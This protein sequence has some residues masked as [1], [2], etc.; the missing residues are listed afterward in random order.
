[1]ADDADPHTLP[2][3][4]VVRYT[5]EEYDEV[6]IS[7]RAG[8]SWSG[9][10]E[11]HDLWNVTNHPRYPDHDGPDID[12]LTDDDGRVVAIILRDATEAHPSLLAVS[13]QK[14]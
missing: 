1:M 9:S 12:V 13:E 3:L 8:E 11:G 5:T 2:I 6:F 7:L 14:E 4:S 10:H